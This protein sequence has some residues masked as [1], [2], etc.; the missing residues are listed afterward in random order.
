MLLA[1][2]S[3]LAAHVRRDAAT[4]TWAFQPTDCSRCACR[5]RRSAIRNPH[6]GSRSFRS[7]CDRVG[8]LPGVTA[9]GLNTGLHP[10]GN[11]WTAADVVGRRRR[12]PSRWRCTRSARA[13]TTALEFD[14]RRVGSLT[15]SDVNAAQ[16][17]AL[18]N[19]RFV[20][21]ALERTARR[22]ARSSGCH[23]CKQPP[24][25]VRN[26]AFQ[27]VGVVHDVLNDGPVERCRFR[28]STCRSP[29]RVSREPAGGSDTTAIRPALTR[30][31]IGQVYAIDPD[32][33]CTKS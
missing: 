32:S 17:V 10:L 12:A 4:S 31:I 8:A 14:S 23:A 22:S 7:C 3:V 29:R 27:I 15:E 2:S 21:D 30:A 26:E 9:V 19:E 5:C 13:Y 33:P 11:M 25:S 6:G 1:G 28:R 24:F 16:P 20:R 18:V